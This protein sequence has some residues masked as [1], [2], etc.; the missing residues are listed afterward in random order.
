MRRAL[1]LAAAATLGA[2]VACTVVKTEEPAS[3]PS[4]VCASNEDCAAV[5]ESRCD[6]SGA[7]VL[8]DPDT[9]ACGSVS[10]L[11]A[12]YVVSFPSTFGTAQGQ[13]VVIERNA[14]LAASCTIHRCSVTGACYCVGRENLTPSVLGSYRVLAAATRKL[15]VDLGGDALLPVR[16]VFRPLSPFAPTTSLAASVGVPLLALELEPRPIADT[17]PGPFG[18]PSLGWS[19]ALPRGSYVR[20]M[21]PIPPL[22]ESFPPVVTNVTVGAGSALGFTITGGAD[23]SPKPFTI[24]TDENLLGWTTFMR[25]RRLDERITNM[26]RLRA[27]SSAVGYDAKLFTVNYTDLAKEAV[28]LVVRPP[29]GRAATPSLVKDIQ[30]QFVSNQRIPFPRILPPERVAGFVVG[31]PEGVPL[32]ASLIFQSVVDERGVSQ[33]EPTNRDL[34]YTRQIQTDD[35]G[36]FAVDLPPGRYDVAVMPTI[37]SGFAT[38]SVPLVPCWRRRRRTGPLGRAPRRGPRLRSPHRRAAPSRGRRCGRSLASVTR[39]RGQAWSL[40]RARAT[41]TAADGSFL[42]G[43]DPGQYDL[44][45]EPPKGSRFPVQR[46]T[47]VTVAGQGTQVAPLVSLAPIVLRAPLDLGFT[48][49]DDAAGGAPVSGAMVRVLVPGE[50]GPVELAWGV[51]DRTGRVDLYAALPQVAAAAEENRG[52]DSGADGGP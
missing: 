5:P 28:D 1:G 4:N 26:V 32:A 15:E 8:C 18:S 17:T 6:R 48:M 43:V 44:V 31:D 42:L 50:G 51:T 9:L 38:R 34:R 52:G 30:G 37:E 33:L 21:Q 47:G 45:V 3:G 2:L 22:D 27:P 11:K 40:A 20:V 7:C 23:T 36:R 46:V 25:D 41:V 16:T 13:T 10:P 12:V 49:L 24:Q 39:A 14:N 29:D 19:A 35:G